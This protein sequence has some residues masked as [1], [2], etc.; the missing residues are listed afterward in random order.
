MAAGAPLVRIQAFPSIL[1]IPRFVLRV[2]NLPFGVQR[3]T[4]VAKKQDPRT[5][6]RL[7]SGNDYR[8]AIKNDGR[9]VFLDGEEVRDVTTH[10]A[11]C[12]GA[13]TIASL[14]DIA[15]DPANRD[16]MTF[17]S[18]S[19]GEPVNRIWQVP[20]SVEDLRL[21]RKAIERWSEESFGFIG[22]SPD[23]VAGF[24]VGYVSALEVLSRNGNAPYAENC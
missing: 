9:R 22:R 15:S 12:E 20:Y 5:L 7:R 13:A 21:R 19:T 1:T 2:V 4:G 24:F 23:H 3:M 17:A 14:F 18:P 10:P 11:F 16:L 8:D 6:G